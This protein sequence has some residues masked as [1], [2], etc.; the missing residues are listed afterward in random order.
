[1]I[2]RGAADGPTVWLHGCVH[3]DEYCG[4]FIVHEVLRSVD[5]RQLAGTVVA[6]PVLNITAFHSGRRM[7]PFGHQPGAADAERGHPRPRRPRP[8]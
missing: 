1:M 5:P 7:S 8:S 4:A 2:V 3:G 6:L